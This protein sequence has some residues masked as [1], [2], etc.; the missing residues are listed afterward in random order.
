MEILET[1]TNI[2]LIREVNEDYT[3]AICH[4]KNKS[5]KLLVVADGMGG[6]EHGEI[7]SNYITES[8]ERWF[9][10]KDVKFLNKTEEVEKLLTRY[11]KT[12]N[13]NL[14]KKIYIL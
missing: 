8:L 7:A 1:K 13:N 4:P 12:L 3:L 10:S 9:K 5:I 2:G 11:I 6:R 14:I